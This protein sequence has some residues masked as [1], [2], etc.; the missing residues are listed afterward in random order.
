MSC[1][2]VHSC[3]C[4]QLYI[5]IQLCMYTVV[6]VYIGISVKKITKNLSVGLYHPAH[7]AENKKSLKNSNARFGFYMKKTSKSGFGV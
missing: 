5:C 7:R 2:Y 3:I 1:T 6:Y 4:I